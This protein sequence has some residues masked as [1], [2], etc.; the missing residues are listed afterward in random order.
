MVPTGAS[1]LDLAGYA[2]QPAGQR[3]GQRQIGIGVGGRDAVLDAPRRRVGTRN[4]ERGRAVVVAPFGVDRRRG[5]LR[6]PAVR[7]HI[8]R[9]HHQRV[10]H[11]LLH[12]ADEVPK[13]ASVSLPSSSVKMFL[14]V[15]LSMTDWWMCMAEPGWPWMGLAMKVA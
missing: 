9:E 5:R 15:F 10:R 6:Q 4:A 3:G 13:N 7:V 8:G 2:D 1:G 14:P 12:A 11:M